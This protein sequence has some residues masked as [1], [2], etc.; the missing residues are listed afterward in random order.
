[1]LFAAELPKAA[2]NTSCTAQPIT[3]WGHAVR[4]L[5]GLV[6]IE[7]WAQLNMQL[8]PAAP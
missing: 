6:P 1:M 3:A 4:G 5:T 8:V 2:A 7:S